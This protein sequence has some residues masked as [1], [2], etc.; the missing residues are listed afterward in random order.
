MSQVETLTMTTKKLKKTSLSSLP[1]EGP[2]LTTARIILV[3]NIVVLSLGFGWNTYNNFIMGRKMPEAWRVVVLFQGVLL[4]LLASAIITLIWIKKSLRWGM[5]FFTAVGTVGVIVMV[6]TAILVSGETRIPTIALYF[7]LGIF[8]LGMVLGFGPAALY[9]GVATA[10]LI[11]FGLIL[12]LRT[13]GQI[14]VLVAMAWVV[15]APAWLVSALTQSLRRSERQF[16]TVVRESLDGILVVR[17]ADG[18]LL[19]ANQAAQTILHYAEADLIQREL[20]A[21]FPPGTAPALA[22]LV[23][24]LHVHNAMRQAQ[25]VLRADGTLCPVEWSATLIPW[26]RGEVLLIALHDIT[27]RRQAEAERERFTELLRT[28][29]DLTGQINAILDPHQLLDE[30]LVQL[31]QR[32]TVDQVTLDRWDETTQTLRRHADGEITPVPEIASAAPLS[33]GAEPSAVSRRAALQREIVVVQGESTAVGVPA[34]AADRLSE[35]AIPLL[36]RG[37]L[38]GVLHIQDHRPQRFQPADLDV[39]TTLAGQ[40][41]TALENARLFAAL[42]QNVTR[43]QELSRRLVEVQENERRY[44]ACELHDEIG[45][46]LTGLKLLLDMASHPPL[47]DDKSELIEEAMGLTTDLIKRVRELSLNLRPSMLDNL[48]LL[49]TLQWYFGRYTTQTR[50]QVSF[51]QTGLERRFPPSV[52]TAAYRI[53]QEGLTNVAR[54]A[55][56]TAASVRLWATPDTLNV[57]IEDH[58][59]GFDPQ[60]A[61]RAHNSSGLTGMQERAALLGGQCRVE[62]G[63]GQGTSVVAQFPL[64]EGLETSPV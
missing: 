42:Q 54:H 16:R 19:S 47:T 13:M 45:Q 33:Q 34:P 59:A 41:A 8:T 63:P 15:T 1:D 25:E 17:I 10:I 24:A 61:L 49:P 37:Q 11:M 22:D 12:H 5:W 44:I 4:V 20:Q 53:I 14:G 38:L 30:L 23:A 32:F 60:S 2:R 43:L 21:L 64:T 58:G 48:G 56:V 40:V 29:A 9:A 26:E 62:S 50:I 55:G 3:F 39:F 52:E 6:L 7:H 35:V 46:L 31:P 51:E 27:Q 57:L 28:A 18:R 36:A